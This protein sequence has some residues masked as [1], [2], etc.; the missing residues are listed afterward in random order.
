MRKNNKS[1]SHE[2]VIVGIKVMKKVYDVT[3]PK[4]GTFSFFF[5]FDVA[6]L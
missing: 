2:L 1:R 3:Y 6:V 4:L 5:S